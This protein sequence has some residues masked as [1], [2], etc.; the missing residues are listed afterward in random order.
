[1]RNRG[2]VI[3][4]E[5]NHVLLIRRE[6]NGGLYFVFPGGGIE[7]EEIPEEAAVREAF[8]ELGVHVKLCGMVDTIQLNGKQYFFRAE[9]LSG[10]IGTGKGD[11]LSKHDRGSYEP[12]F[13][14]IQQLH[15]LPVFPK[16][17]ADK[18]LT[19]GEN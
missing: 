2:S 9:I 5:D 14:P 17:I 12:M 15:S 4:I 18:V 1:M 8:E 10:K 19:L 16:E 6:K 13:V 3:I 7:T 11:E